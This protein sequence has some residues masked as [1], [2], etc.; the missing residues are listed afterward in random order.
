MLMLAFL[1]RFKANF[2]EEKRCYPSFSLSHQ[3]PKH[4]DRVDEGQTKGVLDCLEGC[5]TV[6]QKKQIAKQKL[7]LEFLFMSQYSPAAYQSQAKKIRRFG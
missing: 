2:L 7:R 6:R 4:T 3:R 1:L 5:S